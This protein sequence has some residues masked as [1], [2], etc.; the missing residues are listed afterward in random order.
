VITIFSE[1]DRYVLKLLAFLSAREDDDYITVGE[2]SDAA[3]IPRGYLGKIVS[4]L[5]K[6]GYLETV[7]GPHGGIKLGRP[8]DEITVRNLLTDIE[9]LQHDSSGD[10]CCV[11]DEFGN[12]FVSE[13]IDSFKNDVLDDT[14]IAELQA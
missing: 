13:W 3:S 11:T 5:S 6:K 4:L 7:Q 14:T 1:R 12:C 2:V 9:S 8:A 10:L